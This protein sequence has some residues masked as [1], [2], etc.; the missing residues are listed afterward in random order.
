MMLNGH[1]VMVKT[2]NLNQDWKLIHND[3]VELLNLAKAA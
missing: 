3:L 1:K 2:I